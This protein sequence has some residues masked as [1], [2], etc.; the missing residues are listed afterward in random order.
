MAW[1]NSDG[2]VEYHSNKERKILDE[3]LVFNSQT[4]ICLSVPPGLRGKRFRL[5]VELV[6]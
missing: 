2:V 5:R 1:V 3:F 6:E 4:N